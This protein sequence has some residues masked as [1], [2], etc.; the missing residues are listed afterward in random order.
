LSYG[1][2]IY[3]STVFG[4][5]GGTSPVPYISMDM[6][7]I[8]VTPLEPTIEIEDIVLVQDIVTI[9]INAL[10]SETEQVVVMDLPTI[11]VNPIEPESNLGL[12]RI[13]TEVGGPNWA[14]GDILQARLNDFDEYGNMSAVYDLIALITNIPSEGTFDIQVLGTETDWSKFEKYGQ[15]VEFVRRGNTSNPLRQDSIVVSTDDWTEDAHSPHFSIY[16]GI[17]NIAGIDGINNIKTRIGNLYACQ[18]GDNLNP[19]FNVDN[20]DIHGIFNV[21][22]FYSGDIDGDSFFKYDPI[23]KRATLKGTLEIIGGSGINNLEDVGKLATRDNI[24]YNE[25]I[26]TKPP[27][28]ATFGASWG[29]NI[30]NIPN[31]LKFSGTPNANGTFITDSFIGVYNID[32][33]GFWPVSMDSNGNFALRDEAEDDFFYFDAANGVWTVGDEKCFLRFYSTNDDFFR[34]LELIFESNGAIFP[35]KILNNE[36]SG[37]KVINYGDGS[38]LDWLYYYRGTLVAQEAALYDSVLDISQKIF[39]FDSIHLEGQSIFYDHLKVRQNVY[40][41]RNAFLD[42]VNDVYLLDTSGRVY[43]SEFRFYT[44]DDT[45]AISGRLKVEGGSLKFSTDGSVWTTIV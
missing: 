4:T 40:I 27:L 30:V 28:N 3:G 37:A 24:T 9:N 17:D 8:Q 34:G 45:K 25:I 20:N 21:G 31:R 15:E 22:Y 7:S 6:P 23:E 2:S 14:V 10:I 42:G 38:L 1:S 44:D 13:Q 11:S 32:T 26:G 41:K 33:G 29:T 12:F 5:G 16:D 36:N 19:I 35:L 39:W 18:V 43:G